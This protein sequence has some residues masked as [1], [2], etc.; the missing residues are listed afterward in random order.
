MSTLTTRISRSCPLAR[1][2][3]FTLSL[4]PAPAA[5]IRRDALLVESALAGQRHA[6][7]TVHLGCGAHPSFPTTQPTT[8][9]RNTAS[10]PSKHE[11]ALKIPRIAPSHPYN[12]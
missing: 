5:G 11:Q 9:P 8:Q 12:P 10:Q 1:N 4:L 3:F 7:G 6:P 2:A